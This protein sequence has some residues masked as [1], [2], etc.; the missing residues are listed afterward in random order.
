[1]V[2]NSDSRQNNCLNTRSSKI[3][4]I[5]AEVRLSLLFHDSTFYSFRSPYSCVVF[6]ATPTE[7][8]ALAKSVKLLSCP[9]TQPSLGSTLC[10]YFPFQAVTNAKN[11]FNVKA[12]F[13]ETQRQQLCWATFLLQAQNC[14]SVFLQAHIVLSSIVRGKVFKYYARTIESFAYAVV[15]HTTD[16]RSSRSQ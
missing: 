14:S 10:S 4:A 8:I 3:I 7:P 16:S 6:I 15:P 2:K 13:P 12:S 9:I 1:M 11:E 5:I